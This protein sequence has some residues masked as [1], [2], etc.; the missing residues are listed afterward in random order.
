MSEKENGQRDVY[1][2]KTRFLSL[3][4]THRTQ[5]VQG[6]FHEQIKQMHSIN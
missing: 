5:F 4:V 3:R 1:G 6:Q 2:G